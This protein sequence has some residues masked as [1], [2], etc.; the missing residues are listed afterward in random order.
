MHQQLVD[1]QDLTELELASIE[2]AIELIASMLVMTPCKRASATEIYAKEWFLGSSEPPPT[3]RDQLEGISASDNHSLG[4]G[5]R[6]HAGARLRSVPLCV[7]CCVLC[8]HAY[9]VSACVDKQMCCH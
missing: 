2:Q 3:P 6:G 4:A 9:L 8:V 5:A 1:V 7:V